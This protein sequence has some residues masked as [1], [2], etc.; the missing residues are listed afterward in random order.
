MA[1]VIPN[2]LYIRFQRTNEH[3][4]WGQEFYDFA[5]LEKLSSPENVAWA[6]KLYNEPSEDL[7][8]KMV[9]AKVDYTQ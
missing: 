2:S 9:L 1:F 8:K 5:K 4:R 3:L 7:A 6:K